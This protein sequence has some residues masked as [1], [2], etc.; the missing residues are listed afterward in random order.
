MNHKYRGCWFDFADDYLIVG[1][2]GWESANWRGNTMS[3]IGSI[4]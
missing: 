4:S 2:S 1:Y 3:F